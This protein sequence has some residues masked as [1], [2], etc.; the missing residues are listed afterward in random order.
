MDGN[1]LRELRESKGFNQ[2]DFARWLNEALARRYDKARVSRWESGAE[3]IPQPVSEFIGGARRKREPVAVAIA[4]QKGGVGKTVAAV[5][6]AF[7]L[8]RRGSRVLLIDADS[9]SNAS[10]HVGCTES[11]IV[12][13][14][15]Q[16]RTLY[17]VLLGDQTLEAVALA[18]TVDSLFLAP[19][20]VTLA[21]ADVELMTEPG[22]QQVLREKVNAARGGF[23][24]F[25]IDCTPNLGLVTINAL[26]AADLVLLPVQ[27]EAFAM[28]GVKRLAETVVKVQRR[29]NP[30]LSVLGILPT[31]YSKRLSQDQDSLKDIQRRF[32]STFQVYEP[33]PRSTIYSQAAAA[34]VIT[35]QAQPDA[36]GALVWETIADDVIQHAERKGGHHVAA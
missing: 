7:E 35:V 4:N 16:G 14:E 29:A 24:F 11:R 13:L 10:I 34:G 6:L 8:A 12:E 21:D 26:A 5:N 23:D 31:M 2:T 27:T 19:S 33:I 32:G 17:H 20:S 18:T 36:P 28:L 22:G 1:T 9:Q 3:R 15:G 25:V 30:G